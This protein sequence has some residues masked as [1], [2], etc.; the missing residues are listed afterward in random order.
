MINNNC[1]SCQLTLTRRWGFRNQSCVSSVQM[2]SA[3]TD[4]ENARLRLLRIVARW[5]YSYNLIVRGLCAHYSD[6][7]CY[8]AV[9]NINQGLWFGH[10][11]F[12]T[13][14]PQACAHST[15]LSFFTLYPKRIGWQCHWLGQCM[16][17]S[18]FLLVQCSWEMN[19]S[20]DTA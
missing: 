11:L 19:W 3:V 15:H 17:A 6:S 18:G 2:N 4:S 8:S 10:R 13:L 16:D 12:Q 1:Q 7:L 14:Q 20:R 9:I 5:I